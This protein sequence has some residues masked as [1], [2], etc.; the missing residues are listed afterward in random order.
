M[1]VDPN[2]A[3]W[4]LHTS[5]AGDDPDGHRVIAPEHDWE[6]ALA[7]RLFNG[8]SYR[9]ARTQDWLDILWVTRTSRP[10][11]CGGGNLDIPEVVNGI[12][13][14]PHLLGNAG[15]A[16]DLGAKSG[17]AP[18]SAELERDSNECCC[19]RSPYSEKE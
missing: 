17:T 5:D 10:V 11:I 8:I 16:K 13:E 7:H 4:T 14:R 3:L 15:R 18:A 12:T 6:G 2:D 19:A 9:A 1:C